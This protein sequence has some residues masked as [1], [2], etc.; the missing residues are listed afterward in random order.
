MRAKGWAPVCAV[1][2]RT[3]DHFDTPEQAALAACSATPNID[4]RILAVDCDANAT[5]ARVALL[6][7]EP[8][9]VEGRYTVTCRRLNDGQWQ[10]TGYSGALFRG[11]SAVE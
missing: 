8:E 1:A 6:T 5:T 11:R 7:N 4:L 3:V 10:V 2:G 9:G